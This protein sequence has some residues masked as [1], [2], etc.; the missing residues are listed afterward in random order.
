MGFQFPSLTSDMP[1]FLQFTSGS[2]G[3][4]KGVIVT[5]GSLL[6]NC[7]ACHKGF[8]FPYTVDGPGA[9]PCKG[10]EEFPFYEAFHFW[11]ERHKSSRAV[12][13]HRSTVFSWL[14]VYHDMGLI[15]FVCA[16]LMFGVTIIQMSPIDFIRKPYTWLQAMSEYHALATAAPNFAYEL[17][18]RK[19]PDEVFEKL[20]LSRV[21]GWLCGAEPIRPSTLEGFIEVRE[22]VSVSSVLSQSCPNSVPIVSQWQQNLVI[23]GAAISLYYC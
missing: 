11:E 8:G 22:I 10:L 14:P 18:I 5:H 9:I 4:P 3:R 23:G 19:T 12:L 20:D 17:V 13:G 21:C 1:C 6:H 7:H 16:P 15:G 2:T